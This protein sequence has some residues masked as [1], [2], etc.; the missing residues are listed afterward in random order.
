MDTADIIGD[1]F[2]KASI[3]GNPSMTTTAIRATPKLVS[4]SSKGNSSGNSSVA[5]PHTAIN[6]R[7]FGGVKTVSLGGVKKPLQDDLIEEEEEEEEEQEEEDVEGEDDYDPF[8]IEEEEE[9]E[10]EELDNRRHSRASTMNGS[11]LLDVEMDDASSPFD[12]S[13]QMK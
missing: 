3:I 11:I 5:T 8:I 9:G 2:S 7:Q 4:A 13:F 1:R 10:E 12:D 6:V